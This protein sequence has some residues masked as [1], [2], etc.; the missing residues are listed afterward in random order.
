MISDRTINWVFLTGLLL[1]VLQFIQI[2]MAQPAQLWAVV[3]CALFIQRGQI[4]VS[5]A[6]GLIFAMF[7]SFA[8]VATFLSG[9]PHFKATEQLIKFGFLY[10]AFFLIGRTF[11]VH[12]LGHALPYTYM[13]LWILLGLQYMVQFFE[14]PYLYRTVSFMQGALHGTFKERNWL[15]IYFFL[16]SYLLFLQSSRRLVDVVNF[17]GLGIVVTLLSGSKTL[18]IPC[19]IVLLL[20]YPGRWAMKIGMV[21]A[22]TALYVWLFGDALSGDLLRVRLEN[23]RGLAFTQ[24]MKLLEENWLGYGFG[25]VEI[26]FAKLWF[27]IQGLGLGSNSVFSSPLDLMLIAGIPGLLFW[28][29]FFAGIGLRS[30][31]VLAPIATWSLTNPLHQSEVVYLFMG[32]LV[33]WGMQSAAFQ[34]TEVSME[35]STRGIDGQLLEVSRRGAVK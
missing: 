10:S 5:V 2:G 30:M 7:M 34:Q 35:T 32:F 12:Y 4:Q 20:H 26:Y 6:E 3:V 27:G 24:S 15:A 25:F 13:M 19:G 23:E 1:L 33:S 16:A 31:A 22:G 29:V 9:Y 14:V 18:L 11:G 17:I 28:G 21:A 8:L